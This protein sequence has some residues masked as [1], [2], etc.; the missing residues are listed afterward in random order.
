MPDG[1]EAAPPVQDQAPAA[2]VPDTLAQAQRL[3]R[4][5]H[6]LQSRF[7]G[8]LAPA[9][10]PMAAMDWLFH[11]ANRPSEMT[12]QWRAAAAQWR[13]LGLILSHAEEPIMPRPGD[14]RFADPAWRESP[15]AELVQTVLLG[16]EWW[17]GLV[18][19][20][21]GVAEHNRR[22]LSF[23][24]QQWLDMLSPS[25]FPATNPE[26]LT[27]TRERLGANLFEGFANFLREQSGKPNGQA[28]TFRLGQDLATAPGKVVFRN[29]LIELI[30]YAPT[31]PTVLPEPV[32]IVPAWIMK[33]Y[34]LDLSPQN[35]LVR[36]LVGQGRTVFMIS[37]RNPG[38]EMRDMS[39]EDYR[40]MGVMAAIDTVS[41]ILP[42]QKIHLTGYCLGGTLAT[43]TAAHCA[44]VGDRRLASLSLFA[45]QTDFSEAGE[46]QLFVSEDQLDFLEDVM[47]AQGYLSSRQMSSAFQMLRP[48]DLLWSRI[49][50]DYYL[51]ESPA[52]FDLMAW[53]AD[54]TRMPARMHGEYLRRLYLHNDLAEGRL[55]AGGHTMALENIHLPIFLVGTEQDH[56]APWH[57][58]YKLHFLN[59]GAITFVLTTGGHNAGIVSEPGHPRRHFRIGSRAAGGQ[60]LGADEWQAATAPRDGSW[61]PEWAAWLGAQS[62]TTSAPPPG[63]SLPGTPLFGDAPGA[64]VLEEG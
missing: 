13:R 24:V 37:W 4:R 43:I 17:Q 33:Y 23:T 51:G 40:E 11:A 16:E 21:G 6:A 25:N 14:H 22:L 64:Y 58:V 60:T 52:S 1:S 56:I 29:A 15:Y 36:F 27:T 28:K 38:A 45:A 26:I 18:E 55:M 42:E 31:T 62:A 53:N 7:T 47:Q 5:L 50:R 19:A 54:G 34:I 48:N 12:E 57:S 46:L 59:D 44:A 2:A 61:W 41:A 3:D 8:G 35:S 10:L 9:S 32:L 39:L 30:Q 49:I 63:M 20:P